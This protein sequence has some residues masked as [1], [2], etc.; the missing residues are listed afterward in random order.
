MGTI[1]YQWL[2]AGGTIVIAI[3][4][5][6]L[7]RLWFNLRISYN[8]KIVP[9]NFE[10]IIQKLHAFA[11]LANKSY[12]K[13]NIQYL[14]TISNEDWIF[15]KFTTIR[16]GAIWL[17]RIE[18]CPDDEKVRYPVSN[19]D[20]TYVIVIRGSE[21]VCDW[22][23]YDVQLALFPR[24][25]LEYGNQL[26]QHINRVLLQLRLQGA[27]VVFCGHSL[28]ASL[29]ELLFRLSKK[30][31]NDLNF[32]PVGAITFDSPGL[33]PV[34]QDIQPN[35]SGVII[36]NSGLNIVNMLHK[37]CCEFLYA[38]GRGSRIAISDVFSFVKNLSGITT[39]EHPISTILKYLENG[40]VCK[41]DPD[42]WWSIMGVLAGPIKSIRRL[43]TVKP[44]PHDVAYPVADIAIIP[45]VVDVINNYVRPSGL[46]R[47]PEQLSNLQQGVPY[48]VGFENGSSDLYPFT[49]QFTPGSDY[50]LTLIGHTGVGKSS[51][52]KALLGNYND[53]RISV[54]NQ[55]NTTRELMIAAYQGGSDPAT[56]PV[57]Q[58][59]DV[60]PTIVDGGSCLRDISVKY[61]MLSGCALVIV[62]DNPLEQLLKDVRDFVHATTFQLIIV[63]NDMERRPADA[64]IKFATIKKRFRDSGLLRD[65]RF[66]VKVNADVRYTQDVDVAPLKFAID[67]VIAERAVEINSAINRN[68]EDDFEKHIA[69]EMARLRSW[70]RF[71]KHATIRRGGAAAGGAA[72]SVAA[73]AGIGSIPA[74]VALAGVAAGVAAAYVVVFGPALLEVYSRTQRRSNK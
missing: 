35:N 20:N 68:Q 7:L 66:A 32:I 51:V 9:E 18:K 8:F 25:F 29:A 13:T 62:K 5:A 43:F 46:Q 12:D 34:L 28:G 54:G 61:R 10:P 11:L 63:Y 3:L 69:E 42:V 27:Q 55:M 33:D 41:S 2:L 50:F 39:S 60:A 58:R 53:T 23:V 64:E 71:I 56:T 37:P 47:V 38:C 44:T 4:I 26:L 48:Y 36:V 30:K 6:L 17:W 74:A 73:A 24:E 49:A 67:L 45:H 65:D 59:T 21:L 57:V 22:L 72:A 14:S 16:E 19:I 1:Q 52:M 31:L 70:D 40:V 15:T